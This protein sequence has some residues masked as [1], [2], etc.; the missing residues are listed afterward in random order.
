MEHDTMSSRSQSTSRN[1]VAGAFRLASIWR[2]CQ[3]RTTEDLTGEVAVITGG[4]RGLGFLLAR[5]FARAGCRVAICARDSAELDRARAKLAAEGAEVFTHVC[6]VSQRSQ[7]EAMI[8]AV[9]GHYGQIDI[10][11]NNAGIIQV[12]PLESMTLADFE[13]AMNVM[14]WGMLYAIWAVLPQMRRR[15]SGRIVNITSVGGKI[16]PPHLI[17]YSAAKFAA[18]GLSE[19]LHAE[20]A[21]DGITVTTIAPGLMRT[22][23]HT[24]AFFKAPMEGEYTWFALGASLPGISMDA[25]RAADQIVMATRNG[26]AERILSTPAVLA[27]RFHGL[28]P[29]A[30]ADILALVNRLLPRPDSTD[31]SRARG[32]EV[33]R[34]LGSH[35]LKAATTFGRSAA[36][37]FNE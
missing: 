22:G 26:E 12:G 11:V 14:F 4:S 30:T 19:G 29:G 18:V 28:F 13:E 1:N 7:V 3:A 34:H 16:S 24:Q 21:R 25:E 31:T 17:P 35:W 36:R 15:H 33:A 9:S 23:S 27:A 37:R 10:L 2:T 20:L 32:K 8:D 5:D 6:D